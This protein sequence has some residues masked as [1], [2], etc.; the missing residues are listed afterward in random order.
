MKEF[1]GIE[2]TARPLAGGSQDDYRQRVAA[3]RAEADRR[4]EH[5]LSEQRSPTNSAADRIRIWERRHQLQ[6]P[7]RHD[8]LLLANI[9]ADTGL[10]L[11]DVRAEQRQRLAARS[12]PRGV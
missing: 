10:T 2:P 11:E 8:H 7:Q 4:R 9:A 12:G 1:D 5:E 6:I 3:L